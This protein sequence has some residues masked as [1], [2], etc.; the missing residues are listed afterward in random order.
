MLLSATPPPTFFWPNVRDFLHI[1]PTS[2]TWAIWVSVSLP[3]H[4]RHLGNSCLPF[5]IEIPPFLLK[6]RPKLPM[7]SEFTEIS[8]LDKNSLEF[9]AF[10]QNQ[11]W[12][13]SPTLL[14]L[15]PTCISSECLY[16]KASRQRN[17]T[18]CFCNVTFKWN[19]IDSSV[20]TVLAVLPVVFTWYIF[21]LNP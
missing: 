13:L 17:E 19:S 15:S 10:R 3:K 7:G 18:K 11:L 20:A 5:P 8:Q 1:L 14:V 12:R 16:D 6:I 9:T 2:F 4:G 21:T